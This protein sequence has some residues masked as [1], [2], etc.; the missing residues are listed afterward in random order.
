MLCHTSQAGR[1]HHIFPHHFHLN[2]SPN[3]SVHYQI[4]LVIVF[5]DCLG[6][7][8]KTLKLLKSN[9]ICVIHAGFVVVQSGTGTCFFPS[10]PR[11]CC[12]P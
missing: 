3:D 9:L 5:V 2:H 8:W 4:V 7:V 12:A 6:L 10:T 11:P 1:E